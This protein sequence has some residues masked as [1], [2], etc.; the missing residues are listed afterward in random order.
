MAR[1]PGNFYTVAGA[2]AVWDQLQTLDGGRVVVLLSRIPFKCPA[3]PY[4]AAM[5]IDGFLRKRHRRDQVDVEIWAAEPLPMGVA[6][7]AVSGPWYKPSQSA[8]S[9]FERHWW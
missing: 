3:A 8:T 2:Q 4:E 5:L 7:P 1:E 9:V 6:G